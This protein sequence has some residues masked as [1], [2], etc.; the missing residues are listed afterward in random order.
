MQAV[1]FSLDAQRY[2]LPLASV[3][4][5]VRAVEVT[6][7]PGAPPV[8]LGAIDVEGAVVAVLD[9]RR[10]FLMPGRQIRLSDHFLIASTACRVVALV[11]DEAHGVVDH[12]MSDVVDPARIA[13]GLEGFAGLV[14][15]EEGLVLIHD[16]EAFLSVDE[17][18]AL[19]ESL[20]RDGRC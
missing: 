13:P 18:R 17:A 16:P 6:P 10:R 4:R 11:I 12:E 15:L 1:V 19:D 8:V 7:L 3:Q 20:R 9:T 2:A 14:K 5:V